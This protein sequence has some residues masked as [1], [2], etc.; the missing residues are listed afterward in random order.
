[1]VITKLLIFCRK[2]L[3]KFRNFSGNEISPVEDNGWRSFFEFDAFRI[4]VGERLLL[5]DREPVPIT[6]KVFDILLLL[7]EN[8]GRTVS[9][10]EL[11][12]TIWKNTFVYDGN[13]NKNV[14]TLRKSLGDNRRRP[15]FITTVPKRGYRFDGDVKEIRLEERAFFAEKR[16][17]YRFA[18]NQIAETNETS[19]VVLSLRTLVVGSAVALVMVFAAAWGLKMIDNGNENTAILPADAQA[20]GTS[21]AE[22]YELY[23]DGRRLWQSRAVEDLHSA[24]LKLELAVQKDPH[25]ARA[26]AAL[27]DA[28]AF[29]YY[30]WV[31]A[32][33]VANEAISKD[34]SLAEPYA[35]I[36]FIRTF[37]EWRPKDAEPYFRHAIALNPDY[38]TA[39]QWFSL[40]LAARDRLGMATAEMRRAL[41]LEPNSPSINSDLC[42]MLYFSRQYDLA[43]DQ[44]RKALD[45]APGLIAAHTHLYHIYTASGMYDAAVDLYFK[46][47]ELHIAPQNKLS[48]NESLR[49]AYS[50]NGIR[51]FWKQRVEILK[52][53]GA[54]EF[55][56]GQYYARL[57]DKGLAFDHFKRAFESRDFDFIF[58]AVDPAAESKTND[59]SYKQLARVLTAVPTN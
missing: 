3:T 12:D 48:E 20:L 30:N 59:S 44:C 36:G 47:Q 40:S 46:M 21:D 8:R 26:H 10:D 52:R 31:K 57:G 14:S 18:V 35:T 27:A 7:V 23:R 16:T 39:H 1:M 50:E 33:A 5:R 15:K 4:D 55:R 25:F 49:D 56:L 43:I 28:Y 42:Q 37:W 13:L 34:S 45:I 2:I 53:G 6:P 32:E 9:K 29:D 41:E 54:N 58:F 24:T 17:S 22:A 51:S 38:S 11:M 19:R